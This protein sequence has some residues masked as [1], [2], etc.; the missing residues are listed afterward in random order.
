MPEQVCAVAKWKSGKVQR[1]HKMGDLVI[2]FYLS[3]TT[4]KNIWS[5]GILVRDEPSL[6][7]NFSLSGGTMWAHFLVC[8]WVLKKIIKQILNPQTK[9]RK[10]N[11]C[12]AHMWLALVSVC[13]L[14]PYDLSML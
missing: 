11:P 13:P 6:I 8:V 12:A 7:R 10:K 2:D 1:Q 3:E 14:I 5:T 9:K 4:V